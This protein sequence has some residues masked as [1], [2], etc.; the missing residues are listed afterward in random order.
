MND[1]IKKHLK[2]IIPNSEKLA[3]ESK[4]MDEDNEV[5]SLES[6]PKLHAANIIPLLKEKKSIKLDLNCKYYI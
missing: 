5:L 2:T 6:L 3:Y 1:N 4:L